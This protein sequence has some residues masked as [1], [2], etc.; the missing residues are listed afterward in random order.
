VNGTPAIGSQPARAPGLALFDLD[1]TLLPLDSDH[2]FGEHL[3]ALGW[4][5]SESHRAGNDAFYADY[6]AGRLDMTA[7]V[8][9]ATRPLL[10]RSRDELGA[11]LDRFMAETI[12]P[13]IRPEARALVEAH[14]V[15]GD[16][17]A[18]VTATNDVVTAPI[19][20]AFGIG[21]LIATRLARDAEGRV[22]GAIDGRPSYREGKVARVAEWLACDGLAWSD[23]GRITVYGDS[24]ADLP[25]LERATQPVATNP[26]PALEAVARERGWRV[27]NLFK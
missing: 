21:H 9:F 24:P 19:A 16:R 3:I 12:G 10:G 7:Y 27:L 1:G 17:L 23:F 14:R 5:E 18:L 11:A 20:A 8:A 22:T 26:S 2:A 25:L 13:A 6:L 15:R 4:A